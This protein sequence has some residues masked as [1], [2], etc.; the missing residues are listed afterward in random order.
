MGRVG[1]V[2]YPV[3]VSFVCLQALA[4]QVEPPINVTLDCRNLLQN[5]LKWS[6]DGHPPGLRFKVFVGYLTRPPVEHWVEP[7]TQQISLS[8][9]CEPSEDYYLSVTAVVGDNESESAPPE[10]INFSYFM[11][12]QASQKCIVD[13]PAVNVT[14][15]KDDI[16]Q[17]HFIHPWWFHH[18]KGLVRKRRSHDPQF[19]EQLPEFKYDVVILNQKEQPHGFSC[20]ESVC[21]ETLPVDTAQQT[22]CLKIK[23][24]MQGMSVIATQDYCSHPLQ[25]TPAEAN[26]YVYIIVG[27]VLGLIVLV[28]ILFMVY[29]KKTTPSSSLPKSMDIQS[30]LKHLTFGVVQE[31]VSVPEVEPH[32]PTPLL[33]TTDVTEETHV[34]SDD[35]RLRIGELTEDE[36][37]C[38]DEEKQKDEYRQGGWLEE[39]E[40][41]NI[42][43]I[44]SGY[45]RRPVLVE[46]APDE[47]AEGYRH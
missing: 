29:K 7:P 32:S 44:R 15:Q 2:F 5:V 25:K 30:R 13:L 9:L 26:F 39:D 36:V 34:S 3:L 46:L 4:G 22:H 6:Y 47:Q 10:G 40:T 16:V 17:L 27:C 45:E 20:V 33:P 18:K 28:L 12:S 37:V 41:Q 23:G 24:E 21:E 14:A 38:E 43:E 8:S 1:T 11:D 31:Q 19:S 35:I 42:G